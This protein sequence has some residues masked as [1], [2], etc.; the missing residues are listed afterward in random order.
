[1]S[2]K[3]GVPKGGRGILAVLKCCGGGGG[4]GTKMLWALIK[5]GT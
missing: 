3:F 2:I 4:C 5:C 1:M